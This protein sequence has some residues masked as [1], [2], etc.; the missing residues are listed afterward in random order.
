MKYSRMLRIWHWL[1]AIAIFGL[2]AT[3]LL[4]KTF[5]S[6]RDNAQIIIDTAAEY[7]LTI[8]YEV[9]KSIAKAIREPMWEWHILFGYLLTMLVVF[10]LFIFV[11]EGIAYIDTSSIH[12]KLITIT[13]TT[14]YTLTFFMMLSGLVL[15]QSTQL[16][17]SSFIIHTI[18]ELHEVIAWFFVVFVPLHIMGVVVDAMRNKNNIIS[19]MVVG[20][21]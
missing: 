3:F 18:K 6:W 7:N 12:K 9:A 11:K 10:R 13:Y 2:L 4:R 19:K 14:F 16:G 21:K 17:A 5:L 8:S 1:N 20:D 15:V